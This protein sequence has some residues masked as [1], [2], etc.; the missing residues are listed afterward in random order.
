MGIIEQ[1][2]LLIKL[3]RYWPSRGAFVRE[4]CLEKIKQERNRLKERSSENNPGGLKKGSAPDKAGDV[5]NRR[6]D[7][8]SLKKIKEDN[9]CNG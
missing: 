6:R 1:I 4:A 7:D 8:S 9:K 3:L 2:D 5:T